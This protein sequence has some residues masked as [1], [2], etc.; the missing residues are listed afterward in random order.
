MKLRDVLYCA[1]L[2]TVFSVIS[3]SWF[4]GGSW[5]V[6][7]LFLLVG[8]YLSIKICRNA[9]TKQ[10]RKVDA[11]DDDWIM[12]TPFSIK[13][14]ADVIADMDVN[15]YVYRGVATKVKHSNLTKWLYDVDLTIDVADC[16]W[17]FKQVLSILEEI[18]SHSY[19]ALLKASEEYGQEVG[20]YHF[21]EDN[22]RFLVDGVEVNEDEFEHDFFASYDIVSTTLYS[23]NE[24]P[25]IEITASGETTTFSFDQSGDV[26]Q[27]IDTFYEGSDGN[28]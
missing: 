14:K 27:L 12:K 7:T 1:F 25:Y 18:Q 17:S 28:E 13:F 9:T 24:T 8:G 16:G 21:D 6:G 19:D 26:L 10:P 22:D 15:G 4:A 20:D 23:K 2:I 3:I 5:I 11:A